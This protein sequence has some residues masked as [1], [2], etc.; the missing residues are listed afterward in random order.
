M[1]SLPKYGIEDELLGLHNI[2]KA[3]CDSDNIY[4]GFYAGNNM[5]SVFIDV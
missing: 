3:S 5:F 4:F 2:L 1:I